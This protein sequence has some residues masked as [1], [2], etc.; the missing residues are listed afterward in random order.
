[1]QS[2]QVPDPASAAA[3]QLAAQVLQQLQCLSMLVFDQRGIL[4]QLNDSAQRWLDGP[5]A[6]LLGQPAGQL[7]QLP[8][9][10]RAQIALSLAAPDQYP[11][12]SAEL[13]QQGPHGHL[14]LRWHLQVIAGAQRGEPWHLAAIALNIT[15]ESDARARDA[16]Q[17]EALHTMVYEDELTG[18]ASRYSER[19]CILG[20]I[21]QQQPFGLMAVKLRDFSLL[22]DNFGPEG[23]DEVICAAARALKELAPPP[24]LLT[25]ASGV[26][27]HILVPG[28]AQPTELQR[29]GRSI[30]HRF[31]QPLQLAKTDLTV[32]VAIGIACHPQHGQGLEE[33]QRN[34]GTALHSAAE[35]GGRVQ[36]VF[37]PKM[38]QRA[39]ERLW[40]DHHL[41][42]ALELQQ[43]EL[44]YQ[45]KVGLQ[46][47]AAPAVEALLRWRHPKRGL[48]RPD[49]FVARAEGNGQIIAM[50]RWVIVTAAAQAAQWRALGHAVRIAVNISARQ[51]GDPD[52]L[53]WLS[54][55]QRVAHGLLDVELTESCV[56]GDEPATHAFMQECRDLGFQIYLDDFGT[57]FSSL[58]QLARLPIDVVK[59]DRSFVVASA[60][61]RSQA[62]MRSMVGVARELRLQVIAEGV[63]T[64]E[65]EA[66]LREMG[67]H[68]AQGWLY[69]AAM[70]AE[71]Y[72]RWLSSTGPAA[73]G[74]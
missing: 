46:G 41:R 7:T 39:R 58:A 72:L 4:C 20:L 50:G 32:S 16:L 35:E 73:A 26:E 33:L 66:L 53:R 24:L 36:R 49:L 21:E 74:G 71:D 14:L 65:Q 27:F 1:M 5:G 52:L 56:I 64:R 30:L 37:E 62:L 61:E 11:T 10:L 17:R 67:V 22:L 63:E 23:A 2:S 68:A 57:G 31:R 44:H 51:L 47:P 34:V 29:L 18:L 59:L 13:E 60:Q 28:R 42:K 38:Q 43:L 55:C 54:E 19:E 48:I 12:W 69:A 6:P 45:P 9:E 70:P 3:A 40:L 25:R 15:A 8:E